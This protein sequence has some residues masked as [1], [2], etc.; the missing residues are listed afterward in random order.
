MFLNARKMH[1]L[2]FFC[3][4]PEPTYIKKLFEVPKN[5]HLWATG[6]N[7]YRLSKMAQMEKRLV[8]IEN[9]MKTSEQA[10][11]DL[12]NQCESLRNKNLDLEKEVSECKE[13]TNKFEEKVEAQ[14]RAIDGLRRDLYKEH[15][16]NISL[17][18]RVDCIEQSAKENNVR[19]VDL[20]ETKGSNLTKQVVELLNLPNISEE[21]IHS[22]Y[23]LGKER[24]GRIRD[25]IVRFVDKRKR[26]TFY[27]KRKSTPKGNDDKKVFINDDLTPF[28][29]KLFFDAR[30]LAKTNW[31]HSTWTQEGNI[32]IKLKEDEA[33]VAVTT[34]QEL[35]AKVFGYNLENFDSISNSSNEGEN[36]VFF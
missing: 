19:I 12:Q 21:D 32:L 27:S 14:C 18:K 23:R 29:S 25:V 33:P 28:R 24:D 30:R 1:F 15:Q 20:P 5:I 34:H 6:I 31:I 35:R 9:F 26:D 36:P 16:R 22:T 3:R 8:T 13:K 10:F 7:V 2:P 17:D 11:Q 4:F